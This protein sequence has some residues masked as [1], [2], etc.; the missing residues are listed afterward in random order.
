MKNG[1]KISFQSN[2]APVRNRPA[3]HKCIPMTQQNPF[4]LIYRRKCST[5]SKKSVFC[6][7]HVWP[8][9]LKWSLD[10]LNKR[11]DEFVASKISILLKSSIVEDCD[12]N[13]QIRHLNNLRCPVLLFFIAIPNSH[14]TNQNW[15]SPNC[16]QMTHSRNAWFLPTYWT[17]EIRRDIEKLQTVYFDFKVIITQ[18]EI[19]NKQQSKSEKYTSP[20]GIFNTIQEKYLQI[21][22]QKYS[23]LLNYLIRLAVVRFPQ[24]GVSLANNNI[25]AITIYHNYLIVCNHCIASDF[26]LLFWNM[27]THFPID[28]SKHQLLFQ[29]RI[30][31]YI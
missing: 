23:Q 1:D 3:R 18:N 19:P 7:S 13:R 11:Y 4:S 21:H 25:F 15:F 10:K 14:V 5:P 17:S 27:I 8:D 26:L 9:P 20:K 30:I 16:L 28:R 22:V 29:D 2:C 31:Y 12:N 6:S 24:W